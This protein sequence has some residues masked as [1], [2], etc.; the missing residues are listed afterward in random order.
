MQ[1]YISTPL[2]PEQVLVWIPV[3]LILDAGAMLQIYVLIIEDTSFQDFVQILTRAIT[4]P[5]DVVGARRHKPLQ[6][7]PQDLHEDAPGQR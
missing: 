6:S 1:A 2:Q 4:K 3:T 5:F 7:D